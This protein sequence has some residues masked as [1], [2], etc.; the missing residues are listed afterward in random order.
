VEW[1]PY[2][3]RLYSNDGY[4]YCHILLARG[5]ASEAKG[6][7]AESLGLDSNKDHLL[8]FGTDALIKARAALA[9]TTPGL[10][11]ARDCATGCAEALVALRKAN[12]EDYVVS[13]LL[14]YAEAL[15]RC[16]NANA[17]DAT[18][19]EAEGIAARGPMPLFMAETQ[20]LRARILLAEGRAAHART[21]RNRAAALIDAHSYGRA[22]PELA[23]L[24]AEIARAEN[25]KEVCEAAIAAAMTAIRGEPYHDKRTGITIDGGWWGLLPRLEALLP[26]GQAELANLR[27]ARDAYNAERDAYLADEEAKAEAEWGEEDRALADPDFRRTLSEAVVRTGHEFNDLTL[28][29]QRA[30]ARVALKHMHEAPREEDASELP[31]IPDEVLDQLLADPQSC[32]AIQHNLTQAGIAEPFDRMPRETQRQAVAAMM[33]AMMQAQQQAA[34]ET[35]APPQPQPAK[36]SSAPPPQQPAARKKGG[37]WPFGRKH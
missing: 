19:R 13:G 24:D 8:D 17:V 32:A 20:L 35:E 25:S 23:V 9:D 4:L 14:A 6:R 10:S 5:R 15:W 28:S 2:Q 30:A 31:D 26:A 18:L 1:R 7:I 22:K 12:Q 29:E 11:A 36:P 3:P 16:G 33:G 21:Y 27:A 37:W 34:E